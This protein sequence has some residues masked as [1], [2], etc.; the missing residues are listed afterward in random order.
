MIASGSI[1]SKFAAVSKRVS[2]LDVELWETSR[3]TTEAPSFLA[4]TSNE[5]LVRVEFS[6]KMVMISFSSRVLS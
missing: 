6:K 4:A 1:A 3:L 5:L 2:P